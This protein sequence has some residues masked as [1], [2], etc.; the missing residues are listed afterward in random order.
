MAETQHVEGLKELEAKLVALGGVA[1]I[2]VLR[3]ALMDAAKPI[4]KA[5]KE[6]V[7]E[8]S[9]ELRDSIRRRAFVRRSG[10]S[11][12]DVYVGPMKPEGWYAHIIEFEYGASNIRAQ[13]FLRPAFDQEVF[14]VIR[15]FS[16]RLAKRIDKVAKK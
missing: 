15:I 3:G 6:N 16:E 8:D 7:P 12:V 10:L 11:A 5:A 9:G 4:V 14:N 1:G 2:K 13:P